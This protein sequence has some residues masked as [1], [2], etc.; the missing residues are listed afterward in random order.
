MIEIIASFLTLFAKPV[1]AQCPICVVTV[2][3]GLFLAKKFGL[4][5]LLASLWISGLNTAVAFW[6]ADMF[7]KRKVLNSGMVWSLVFMAFTFAYLVFSKQM[8]GKYNT[9]WGINRVVLGIL[10]GY[11]VWLFA[12]A[13]DRLIRIKNHGKVLFYYQKVIIPLVLLSLTSG[14]FGM[15]LKVVR[16]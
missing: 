6:F 10:I 7:K 4:D 8:G 2:G 15:L 1:Y 13:I 3:G 16:R 11:V 12:I 5:D 14:I 9:F